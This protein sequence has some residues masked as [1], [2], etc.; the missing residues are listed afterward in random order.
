MIGLISLQKSCGFTAESIRK[1]G[2]SLMYSHTKTDFGYGFYLSPSF[3]DARDWSCRKPSNCGKGAVMIYNLHLPG[4][5]LTMDLDD[6]KWL[7]VVSCAR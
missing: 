7:E 5:F 4:D 6:E 2:I 3:F 1:S